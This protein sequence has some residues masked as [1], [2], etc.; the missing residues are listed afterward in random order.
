MCQILWTLVSV[1]KNC[2]SSKLAC[3][4]N[5]LT[6]SKFVLFS[7]S[8]LKDEKLIKANLHENWNMQ[9]L[10]WSLEYF[11]GSSSKLTFRISSYAVSKLMH[12]L[13]HSVCLI[14]NTSLVGLSIGLKF[15]I[16]RVTLHHRAVV[17]SDG[18]Q[19]CRIMLFSYCTLWF[20]KTSP[21]L[22]QQ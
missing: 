4:L 7:V 10:F 8:G 12:F 1:L 15:R 13:R 9:T 17:A 3:F 14:C 19:C 6:A 21:V 22:Q 2:I 5:K 11:C 16:S 20:K 18:T